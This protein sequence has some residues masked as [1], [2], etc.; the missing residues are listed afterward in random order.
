MQ[1]ASFQ[2]V[3]DPAAPSGIDL[4]NVQEFHAIERMLEP[5]ARDVRLK[6]GDGTPTATSDVDW[7]AVFEASASLAAQ[8]RDLRLLVIVTR[9]LVNQDGL[10]GLTAGLTLINDTLNDHWDSVHPL[11][12]DR[13]DPQQAALRRINSLKQLENDDN[14]LLGDLEMNAMMTLPGL[15]V[16]TGQNLVDAALSEFDAMNNAPSGLGASDKEKLRSEHEA[17]KN[18]V[19]AAC[20]AVAAEQPDLAATLKS[21]VAGALAALN[22]L[23]A[24]FSD[25]AGLANGTGLHFPELKEFLERAQTMMETGMVEADIAEPETS[26]PESNAQTTV[27]KPGPAARGAPGQINSRDDVER[28]LGQIIAF[29]ERTEPSSPIPH[30][31]RRVQRMVHMDFM[32]L[33]SEIAPSGMKEFRNA[34]GVQ[35]NKGK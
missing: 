32:E 29:Y 12:R 14:G 34:A 27:A 19:T 18:R 2:T 1:L 13:D 9:A 22:T 31:A 26:K 16:V 15:G 24:S 8:G 3:I 4:R 33:M 35:D 28:A 25:K 21:D 7:A 6:S 30:L 17:N 5:A 20:R 10:A 23:Q 11:L